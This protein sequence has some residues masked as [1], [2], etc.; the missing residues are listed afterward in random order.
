MIIGYHWEIGRSVIERFPAI[1]PSM[2][3]VK[4]RATSLNL[5]KTHWVF[6]FLSV[7][8]I[9][10]ELYSIG[11]RALYVKGPEKKKKNKRN[12]A[13]LLPPYWIENESANAP[14]IYYLVKQPFALDAHV[15]CLGGSWRQGLLNRIHGIGISFACYYFYRTGLL[16]HLKAFLLISK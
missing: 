12:K 13:S 10:E 11:A 9:A 3:W 8:L 1:L 5:Y 4:N 2:E 7:S 6:V 16:F 14:Y 15:F